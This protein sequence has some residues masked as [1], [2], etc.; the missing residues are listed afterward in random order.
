MRVIFWCGAPLLA[1]IAITS[2]SS[3]QSGAPPP[4]PPDAPA[5]EPPATAPI[6]P[7]APAMPPPAAAPPVCF[8]ECRS[9]FICSAGSCISACNPPCAASQECTADRRCVGSD[10]QRLKQTVK[11][12]IEES[13]EESRQ[14]YRAKTVYRHDG[15]Y[16]RLGIT[17]GYAWDTADNG[18]VETT[19]RGAGGFLHYAFGVSVSEHVVLAG[20]L[21]S[22]G[23]FSPTT[24]LDGDPVEYDHSAIYMVA[25]L[26]VDYYPD[27]AGG[28]HVTGTLGPGV[29]DLVVREDEDTNAGLGLVFGGGHDF[30]VGEQWSL[31]VGGQFAYISGA[32]DNFGQNNVVIPMLLLSALNH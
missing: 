4:V 16:L 10:D 2:S 26:L 21:H 19:A 30:W 23:V 7:P 28:W 31:G 24:S 29:A 1:A 22:L 13:M 12:A 25:G 6:P 11:A 8:P 18:G 14:K 17:A 9:G 32:D 20:T 15:A 27:A 5:L 3:A